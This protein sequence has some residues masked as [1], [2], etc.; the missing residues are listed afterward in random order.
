[1]NAAP[2]DVHR[3]DDDARLGRFNRIVGRCR[4][5]WHREDKTPCGAVA[6]KLVVRAIECR[7]NGWHGDGGE[8]VGVHDV[9]QRQRRKRPGVGGGGRPVHAIFAVGD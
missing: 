7:A 1:M 9:K 2:T 4:A 3:A 6:R 8:V 5:G